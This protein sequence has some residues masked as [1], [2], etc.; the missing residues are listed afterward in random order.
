MI[1]RPQLPAGRQLR[2][3]PTNLQFALQPRLWVRALASPPFP[4]VGKQANQLE[5]LFDRCQTYAFA[6]DVPEAPRLMDHGPVSVGGTE[7]NEPHGLRRSAAA[8]SGDSRHRNRNV[9]A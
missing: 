7:M 5:R 3:P 9:G 8:W 4:L 6:A 2:R 1:A